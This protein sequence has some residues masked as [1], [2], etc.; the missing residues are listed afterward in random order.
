[1]KLNAQ[2]RTETGTRASKKVRREGL[3]PAAI[4]GSSVETFPVVFNR[5]EFEDVLREVGAN[6]V[7]TLDV[8]GDEEYQVFVKE[9]VNAA[10]KDEIYHA[11]LQAFLKGEKV[12]MDIPVYL[13]GDAELEEA[14]ANQSLTEIQI[15]VA[16]ASAPSEYY[17]DV[18]D[19]EIGDSLTVA[20]LE[21][22]GDIEIITELDTT[23][24]S[25]SAPEEIIEPEP[26]EEAEEM[27][28]PEL[29]GASDDDEEEEEE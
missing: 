9:Q 13:E 25:I 12:I 5:R 26:G 3:I 16:P 20:D 28:E 1:M 23:V 24:V 7:F 10:L 2:L 21:L 14:V 18:S 22:E 27:P 4:Y 19:L 15:E 6:G 8:E 11:D 17:V 29:I